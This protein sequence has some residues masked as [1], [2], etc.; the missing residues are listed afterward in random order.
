MKN[1]DNHY[2]VILI[3]DLQ[4]KKIVAAGTLMIEYKFIHNCGHIGHIEDI[5]VDKEERGKN[6]GKW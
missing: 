6:L 1:A 3:E 4:K 5:V 2:F